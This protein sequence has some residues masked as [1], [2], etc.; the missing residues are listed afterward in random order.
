VNPAVLFA[1]IKHLKK[2]PDPGN[3]DFSSN[4][5][6][7][8]PQTSCRKSF[9]FLKREAPRVFAFITRPCSS[10]V[11]S[12]EARLV[13]MRRLFSLRSKITM[14]IREGEEEEE[15]GGR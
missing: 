11:S 14:G 4:V 7:R 6:L 1:G 12:F 13:K 3:K 5:D 10:S 9:A 8:K 15:E 2:I